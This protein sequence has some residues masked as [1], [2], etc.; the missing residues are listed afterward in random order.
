MQVTDE[1]INLLPAVANFDDCPR[2]ID[3]EKKED[4]TS[5]DC[6]AL[7]YCA[8]SFIDRNFSDFGMRWKEIDDSNAFQ[9]HEL[10]LA[11]FEGYQLDENLIVR[12]LFMTKEGRILADIYDRRTSKFK[13]YLVD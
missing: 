12:T 9:D 3:Y 10:Y 1:R 13:A 2:V 5:N 8:M 11:D 7:R 6:W 4:L